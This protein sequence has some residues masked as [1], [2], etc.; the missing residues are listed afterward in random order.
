MGTEGLGRATGHRGTPRDIWGYLGRHL[1]T[2]GDSQGHLG[3]LGHTWDGPWKRLGGDAG[4]SGDTLG[5]FWGHL[6]GWGLLPR[7]ESPW[8]LLRG[9]L[10]SFGVLVEFGVSQTLI[11]SPS[12]GR[13][14]EGSQGG[15]GLVLGSQG[16]FGVGLE[17]IWGSFGVPNPRFSPAVARA[18]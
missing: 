12:W 11:F 1:E 8:V 2:P 16:D 9:S 6:W 13:S 7:L 4:H 5:S 10:R 18:V 17:W 3:T 15:F 14:C